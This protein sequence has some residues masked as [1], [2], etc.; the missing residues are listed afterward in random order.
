MGPEF[1]L[2]QP[3]RSIF[4][5]FI[6]RSSQTRFQELE[7]AAS[8]IE[9]EKLK[10]AETILLRILSSDN[11]DARALNLLGVIRG[12]QGKDEESERLFREAL[13]VNP[14]LTAAH[15]NLGRLFSV[16]K[17]DDRAFEE[18]QA[19]VHLDRNNA[20]AKN[21]L[22]EVAERQAL[23]A[24]NAGDLE[25]SLSILLRTRQEMPQ[26]PRVLYDFGM[27]ALQMKL[28][29][30][31]A[32]AFETAWKIKPDLPN[33]VYALARTRLEQQ[34]LPEAERLLREYLKIRPEDATAHY[35]LARVLSTL[36]RTDEARAEFA[37][38][39]ALQPEQTESYYDLGKLELDQSHDDPAKSFFEKVLERNPKHASALTGMGIAA[40]RNKE[41][42]RAEVYLQLAVDSDPSLGPAHQYY[43][44]TLGRLGQKTKSEEE[45]ALFSRLVA[46]QAVERRSV[47]KLI[48]PPDENP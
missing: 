38:S 15:I 2:P 5:K 31:A 46:E 44:L 25:K 18:Y 30:D 13:I 19:A 35:G 20:E 14:A 4:T 7:E 32:Q 28:Y 12:Q 1:F 27:V 45:L 23:A 22:V 33:C 26:D 48:P 6:E 10:E 40:Y 21:D 34:K 3:T 16:R 42:K 37:R 9:S 8:L 47:L 24:R 17:E 29:E 39:I 43:G 36:L 41:Y 11:S